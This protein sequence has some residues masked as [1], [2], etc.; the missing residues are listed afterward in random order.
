M[1]NA[2]LLFRGLLRAG[3][4]RLQPGWSRYI[5]RL[6]AASAAMVAAVLWLTPETPVWIDWLW[7]RRALQIGLLCAVGI[8]VYFA[9][10][11][12]LGSRIGHL[13]AAV[14]PT[15]QDINR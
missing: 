12:A 9:A 4:F 8:A 6:F 11:W 5:L 14:E 13:R 7:W 15:G 2:G 1:L 10:H 3:F